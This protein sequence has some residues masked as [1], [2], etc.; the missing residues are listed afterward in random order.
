MTSQTL[1]GQKIHALRGDLAH[2]Q[3][4]LGAHNAELQTRSDAVRQSAA[5]Y[6]GLVGEI[7]SRLQL[8]SPPGN[9]ELVAQWGQAKAELDKVGA[10]LSGLN[11]LGNEVAATSALAAYLLKS[12]PAT[13]E[14]SG[15]VEEDHRQLAMMDEEIRKSVIVIDRLRNEVTEAT[16]NAQG[17]F[18]SE[19]PNLTALQVAIDSGEYIGGSLASRAFGVPPPPP[20]GGAAA[21]VGQRQPLVVIR[22]G[23]A[24]VDYEH[25]LFSVVSRALDRKPNAGFDLVAVTPGGATSAQAP[26]A[27]SAS[28]RNA[29]NVLRSLTG[30]GLPSDRVTLS[31]TTSPSAQVNEVHVYVR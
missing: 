26:L 27:A 25:A 23:D 20:P 1:V 2:M 29:E 21:Q 4:R 11:A 8:G 6:H 13:Y 14:L 31:A 5:G 22:F 16:A 28:R 3:A 17:Y 7:N 30:L 10:S 19:R 18:T 15:A 12:V 24:D 9:P